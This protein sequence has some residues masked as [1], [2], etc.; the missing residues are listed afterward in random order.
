MRRKDSLAL[1][2]GGVATFLA[3]ALLGRFLADYRWTYAVSFA[4]AFALL[5]TSTFA[6]TTKYF[7]RRGR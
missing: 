2:V 6:V 5:A 7:G 4:A 1:V 3:M